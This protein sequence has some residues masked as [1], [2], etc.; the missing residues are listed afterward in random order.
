MFIKV[1]LLSNSVSRLRNYIPTVLLNLP[2]T[3]FPVYDFEVR[4]LTG[5]A[6]L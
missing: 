6:K 1:I 2:P 5:E 3:I 4:I